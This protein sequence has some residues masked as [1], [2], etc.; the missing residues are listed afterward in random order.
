MARHLH[1]FVVSSNPE[2]SMAFEYEDSDRDPLPA[3]FNIERIVWATD[4]ELESP[5]LVEILMRREWSL[6]EIDSAL[7]SARLDAT[8]DR[9]SA[10]PS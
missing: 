6:R 2:R 8:L 7:T 5:S 9:T 10:T 1:I 4:R 3:K